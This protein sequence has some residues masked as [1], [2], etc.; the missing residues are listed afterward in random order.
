MELELRLNGEWVESEKEK[1]LQMRF[2]KQYK[3]R[4]DFHKYNGWINSEFR[5]G[6]NF[7]RDNQKLLEH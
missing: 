7:I 6:S 3:A 5:I 2:M 4:P 1:I